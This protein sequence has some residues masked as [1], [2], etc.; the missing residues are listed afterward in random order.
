LCHLSG[1][2]H[3]FHWPFGA[4]KPESKGL[5]VDGCGLLLTDNKLAI[6]FTINGILIGEFRGLYLDESC[7]PKT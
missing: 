2:Q 4:T 7:I 3:Q 1:R 6:F 5:G